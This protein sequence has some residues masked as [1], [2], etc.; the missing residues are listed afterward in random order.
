[1]PESLST[2]KQASKTYRVLVIAPHSSYRTAAYIQAAQ[3]LASKV[4]I[5]SEGEYSIVS[6]FARGLHIRFSEPDKAFHTIITAAQDKPFSG[7]IGTDDSCL[8]LAARVARHFNLPHNPPGAV[9]LAGRKDLARKCL[10][11][12]RVAIPEFREINL[13][14]DI[15]TQV[16]DVDYPV[17]VKPVALSGSRGV[18]R[19][20]GPQELLTA[21]ERV[22]KLLDEEQQL[23]AGLR[24]KLLIEQYIPGDEVAVEGMLHRGQLQI[25]TVFDKPDPLEG[26]F[27]EESY[28]VTPSRHTPAIQQ[29]LYNAVQQACIAYGLNEGPVHAE[30]RINHQGVWILEVAARTIGGL[31]ARLLTF[32]TGHTLEQ[33]VLAQAM[34]KA[35]P[36]EEK[37]PA[38]GVLMIPI[39]RAG[40][41]KRVEGLLEAQRVPGIVDIDIQIREGYELV[42]LP[43]GSSYLGFIFAMADTPAEVEAALRKAHACLNIVVAP[44]IKVKIA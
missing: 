13:S 30:C 24:Q 20:N 16:A 27:F 19:A 8:E 1:M 3:S 32:G 15:S 25:L 34:G 12:A 5:A 44:L 35:L 38:S 41:F 33:L 26:P 29:Q 9:R 36:I 42:P 7:V 10:Q 21:I 17:V 37:R 39:P 4:L 11:Q 18:I 22:K 14:E 2:S 40:M 6:D 28:Y 43:E 31:C 23:D